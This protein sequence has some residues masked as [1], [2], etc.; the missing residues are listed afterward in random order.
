VYIAIIFAGRIRDGRQPS[1]IGYFLP[2]VCYLLVMAPWFARNF[3]AVGA[4]LSP[5]GTMTLWLTDYDDLYSFGKE[6]SW[7]TYLAWGWSNILRAKLHVAWINFQRLWAEGLMIFLLPFAAVGVWRLRRRVEFLPALIYAPLLYAAM[8]LAFTEPGW[9]G[10]WFHSGAALLPFLYA[11]AMEGLDTLVGWVARFRRDWDVDQARLVFSGGLVA[12][13]VLF[14]GYLYGGRVLGGGPDAPS[15]NRRDQVYAD[16]AA[17]LDEH[18]QSD[19]AVMVNSPPTFYYFSGRPCLAVPN[20]DLETLLAVAQRYGGD[21]LILDRN[22]PGPLAALY[23]GEMSDSR[24]ELWA[25]LEDDQVGP[26]R[27]YRIGL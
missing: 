18:V 21:L 8:T 13:A 14:S 4:P 9:R 12:L 22:R 15:W 20:G 24:V 16:L 17:W 27:V 26:V 25:T 5:A 23:E 1:A 11:A 7:R 2:A 3:L 10:G 6:L 19:A